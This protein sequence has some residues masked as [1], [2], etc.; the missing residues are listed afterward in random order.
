M[1]Y[2]LSIVGQPI[3]E[4]SPPEP[5]FAYYLL[6]QA[7]LLPQHKQPMPCVMRTAATPHQNRST[8]PSNRTTDFSGSQS[9]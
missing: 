5:I 8:K 4:A 9:T 6:N 3:Q 2:Q 7:V 1:N